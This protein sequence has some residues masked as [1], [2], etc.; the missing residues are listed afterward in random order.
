MDE[1]FTF[2][3]LFLYNY[4]YGLTDATFNLNGHVYSVASVLLSSVLVVSLIKF[5]Y[6]GKN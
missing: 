6:R 1:G 4:W 5:I 3:K 2:I